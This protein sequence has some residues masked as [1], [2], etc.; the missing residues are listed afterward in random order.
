M[1]KRAWEE[2]VSFCRTVVQFNPIQGIEDSDWHKYP[3]CLLSTLMASA[4]PYS[5]SIV[6]VYIY[7]PAGYKAS[8]V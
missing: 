6:L 3:F 4:K 5:P 1:S 7:R 2:N 8:M